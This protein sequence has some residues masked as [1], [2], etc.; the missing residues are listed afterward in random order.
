VAFS[1]FLLVKRNAYM[2]GTEV[3]KEQAAHAALKYV[4]SGYTLGLGTGSTVKYALEGLAKNLKN[5]TLQ[6]IR[7]VAT[8]SS[9][10]EVARSL[11]IPLVTF[12]E[13]TSLDVYIDGADEVDPSMRLIKGG[14]GAL[15]REK[16]V[17]QNSTVRV[18]VVDSSKLSKR[19]GE[20]WAV[21][22]EVFPFAVDVETEFLKSLSAVPKLRLASDGSLYVTDNGNHIL[23]TNFGEL[24]GV[25]ELVAMLDSRAGVACHGIFRGL[26]DILIVASEVGV[27]E[28]RLGEKDKFLSLLKAIKV[29][30]SD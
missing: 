23:D 22:V 24:T 4:K 6:N 12:K 9:T 7:G 19:I 30:Q 10:E 25:K 29:M 17:A 21:P 1:D 26:A 20:R 3:L 16:I 2:T 11:G 27:T 8:S 15:L 13:V 5:G 18:I 28:L 14:G